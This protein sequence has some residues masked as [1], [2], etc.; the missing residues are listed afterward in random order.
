MHIKINK[1]AKHHKINKQKERIKATGIL[2]QLNLALLLSFAAMFMFSDGVAQGSQTFTTAGTFT[3]GF[4]VP[5][6]VYSITVE[7]WG[8]G[9]GGGIDAANN[10]GGPGGGGGAYASSVI[11]VT[12]GTP[13]TVVVGA[14]GSGAVNG[15]AAATAGSQSGFASSVIALG[16][17][18]STTSTGAQGG[19]ASGSTGDFKS[20]GSNGGNGNTATNGGGGGG[21][22]SGNSGNVVANGAN[23]TNGNGAAGGNGP[24]GD[25]G[26]GGN[27]GSIVMMLSQELHREVEAVAGVTMAEI[28]LPVVREKC[29]SHGRALQLQFLTLHHLFV[30]LLLQRLLLL[31]EQR[32]EYFQPYLQQD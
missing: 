23:S 29:S 12:P 7:V 25:G 5:A 15:G 24:D 14:G 31:M 13:Y 4:T 30:H 10:N 27:S 28:L 11:P 6:G 19:Q 9:G 8:G 2:T 3:N 18:F 20:S 16:G 21:G 17:G 1:M 32:V 22:A 26:R